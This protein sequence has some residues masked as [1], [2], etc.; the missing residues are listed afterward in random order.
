MAPE[1]QKTGL[2]LVGTG[3]SAT[4]GSH[5]L[6][7]V[8]QVF[9]GVR[10]EAAVQ[11]AHALGLQRLGEH[12]PDRYAEGALHLHLPPGGASMPVVGTLRAQVT[13]YAGSDTSQQLRYFV[14]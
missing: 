5:R 1:R 8:G 6:T 12:A 3:F 14:V 9:E 4:L 11:A 10:Q 2:L 7:L 13:C